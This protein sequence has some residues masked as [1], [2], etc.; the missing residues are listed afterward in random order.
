MKVLPG[1]SS[2]TPVRGS[3]GWDLE[4]PT[5]QRQPPVGA[6]VCK[7]AVCVWD[8]SGVGRYSPVK[9]LSQANMA[10]EEDRL[11]L[12]SPS[13]GGQRLLQHKRG[14]CLGLLTP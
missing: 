2:V 10:A 5:A 4:P 9:G 7:V 14:L 12:S 13:S 1:D 6:V 11:L 3:E 8:E